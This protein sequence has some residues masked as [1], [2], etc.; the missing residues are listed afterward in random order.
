[1]ITQ[2]K[3]N[4]IAQRWV[5]LW[6][7]KTIEEYLTQYRDDVVLVS[8]MALR[9]FPDSKGTLTD[10]ELLF[11]YWSLVRERFPNYRFTITKVS[12]FENKIVVFYSTFDEK[13]KAITILTIDEEDMIYRVEVSYV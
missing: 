8:S 4:F 9:L 5:D 6:N 12:T 10:K 13:S 11:K 1:M 3:A 7:D 2:E